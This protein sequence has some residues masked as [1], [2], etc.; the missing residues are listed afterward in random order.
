MQEPCQSKTGQLQTCWR[1]R[2]CTNQEMYGCRVDWPVAIED[3]AD[4]EGRA[5]R[6]RLRRSQLWQSQLRRSWLRRSGAG[7]APAGVGEGRGFSGR[8]SSGRLRWS[9]AGAAPA[10]ARARRPGE[11]V[12]ASGL[13]RACVALGDWRGNGLAAP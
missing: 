4:G 2:K 10:R 6:A 13:A 11:R 7:A 8:G 12:R 5:G 1:S 9:A 3:V